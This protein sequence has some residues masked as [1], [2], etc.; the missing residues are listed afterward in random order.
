VIDLER[1]ANLYAADRISQYP[2]AWLNLEP[3]GAPQGVEVEVRE[4]AVAGLHGL[5]RTRDHGALPVHPDELDLDR[6]R[7]RG[8]LLIRAVTKFG[9]G[10]SPARPADHAELDLRF[11]GR[12]LSRR[13]DAQRGRERGEGYGVCEYVFEVHCCSPFL[14]IVCG[15]SE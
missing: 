5:Q 12:C 11:D 1:S 4:L 15:C 7:H 3:S 8:V 2:N 10:V 9:G 14:V 13:A 6:R